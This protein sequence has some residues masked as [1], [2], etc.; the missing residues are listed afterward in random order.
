MS[1]RLVSDLGEEERYAAINALMKQKRFTKRKRCQGLDDV[2]QE[3]LDERI[4]QCSLGEHHALFIDVQGDVWL[5]GHN[6]NG[7]LGDEDKEKHVT[8]PEPAPFKIPSGAKQVIAGMGCSFFLSHDGQVYVCGRGAHLLF[9]H[10]LGDVSS[11]IVKLPMPYGLTVDAIAIGNEHVLV[12]ASDGRVFGYG[13]NECHQMGSA[14]DI[15]GESLKAVEVV[16]DKQIQAIATG[17]EHSVYLTEDGDVYTCGYS[18]SGALGVGY[19]YAGL[20]FDKTK[21]NKVHIPNHEKCVSITAAARQ[22]YVITESGKVY[23]WGSFMSLTSSHLSVMEPMLCGR[24]IKAGSGGP[25]GP[26]LFGPSL[27]TLPPITKVAVG[28]DYALLL[29][30][31]GQVF[32]TGN[33]NGKEDVDIAFGKADVLH[34]AN[35][36]VA[37]DIAVRNGHDAV[38]VTDDGAVY[39]T[40]AVCK[41]LGVGAADET[42][43]TFHP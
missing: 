42:R 15:L 5:S 14:G 31:D 13:M 2:I 40:P 25:A 19:R 36:E 35:G 8:T 20:G 7:E 30:E 37:A 22:T 18:Y 1:R 10:L 39:F 4:E 24:A 28:A 29:T 6:Y 34:F 9:R 33:N 11:G 12:L 43:L 17:S 41:R 32:V 27:A 26:G 21:P 3:Y 16:K 38:V 23:C